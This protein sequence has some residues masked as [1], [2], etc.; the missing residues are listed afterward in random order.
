MPPGGIVWMLPGVAWFGAFALLILA[1]RLRGRKATL[2]VI[3]A[4]A[5]AGAGILLLMK[6]GP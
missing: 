1:S 4:F 5:L 2:A 6:T 3:A